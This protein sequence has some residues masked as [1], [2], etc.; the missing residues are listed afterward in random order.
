MF[1]ILYHVGDDPCSTNTRYKPQATSGFVKIDLH[2]T[3]YRSTSVRY[4]CP[5]GMG[6]K[7]IKYCIKELTPHLFHGHTSVAELSPAGA[8]PIAQ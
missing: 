3:N 5:T 2:R 4:P 8:N 6:L 1:H 7:N